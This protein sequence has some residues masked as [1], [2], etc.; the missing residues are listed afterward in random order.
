MP[1]FAILVAAGR[2]ERLQADKP[3][4]FVL[5][6][7]ETLLEHAARAFQENA[8]VSSIAAVVPGDLIAEARRLLARF[9]KVTAVAAGGSRRQDSVLE[10]MKHAPDGFTGVVLVHDA[11][12]P[13]V[14][15]R[16]ID[17][18][19]EAVEAHG[20]AIPVLPVVDT[21]KQ[22]GAAG[23]V[24]VTVDRAVLRTVQTPQGFR[25]D[26]LVAAHAVASDDHTDDAGLVERAGGRVDTV[27]G[28]E[29]AFKVTRPFDLVIAEALLAAA[30]MPEHRR[31]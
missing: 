30:P 27:P 10:G 17:A 2:G 24:V 15:T 9:P 19:I 13:L 21:I 8:R 12:R 5:L 1:T 14:D 16:L 25:R 18:V 20:A 23:E 6:G 29:L 28:D 4:A 3:K 22:V 11:A 26:M 7:E 31:R